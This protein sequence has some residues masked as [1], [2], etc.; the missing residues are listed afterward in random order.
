MLLAVVLLMPVAAHTA[1]VS[2]GGSARTAP[3]ENR[4]SVAA[5]AEFQQGYAEYQ[6]GDYPQALADFR[7]SAVQ[8]DARAER[9]LGVMYAHGQEVSQ[10]YAK[11]LKWFHLA[12][13]QGSAVAEYDLGVMNAEGWGVSQNYG[14]ALPWFHL[15]AAQSY[16][17]AE[18]YLGVMNAEGWGVSQDYGKALK[19]YRE[20]AARGYARAEYNLGV[21]YTNG[22]G[23]P[24]DL[25]DYGKA[26]KWFHLAAAQGDASARRA[27]P[28]V[29]KFCLVRPYGA[30]PTGYAAYKRANFSSTFRAND[31]FPAI[32]VAKVQLFSKKNRKLP[33]IL[34]PFNFTNAQLASESVSR[35]A[36]LVGARLLNSWRAQKARETQ[37]ASHRANGD[38]MVMQSRVPA[39]PS[40][41][42]IKMLLSTGSDKAEWPKAEAIGERDG[43]L[44]LH[45]GEH[46]YPVGSDMWSALIQVRPEGHARI[47]WTDMLDVK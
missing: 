41:T 16:A 47:Y 29:F 37:D 35:L 28:D 17:P 5:A 15:A 20:A 39:C 27:S 8:G 30:T 24:R 40:K 7:Q 10:N 45:A 14:K 4:K 33:A 42:D 22:Q 26:L 3:A 13:A 38:Y 46:V 21:M 2:A 25:Q 44:E 23:V 32:C 12:A 36:L 34:R 1:P 18:Y 6:R 11:A 19:W 9:R 31:I 43:C